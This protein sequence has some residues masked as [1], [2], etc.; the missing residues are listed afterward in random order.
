MTMRKTVACWALNVCIALPIIQGSAVSQ[1]YTPLWPPG[2]GNIVYAYCY[3]YY[4]NIVPYCWV[5]LSTSYYAGTNAH[6]HYSPSA[7]LSTVNPSS[8]VTDAS[9]NLQVVIST[10]IVGHA[11]WAACCNAYG[12]CGTYDYA[13]G[14]AGIYW[15]S[16]HG[17]WIQNGEKAIHGNSVAY[18]HWMTST[19]ALGYYY[20]TL[21]Y[22]AQHP[23]LVYSN[24][25]SLPFGGKFDLL[26]TWT[27]GEDHVS[28]DE[29]TAADTNNIPVAYRDEFRLYCKNRGAVDYREEP[30]GSLHCRW[31]Y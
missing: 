20:A 1:S 28:H 27:V 14:I 6:T 3:D 22:Q 29:G 25:M 5:S 24:D 11:E 19:A 18:N 16:D 12:N 2:S 21:D 7:P 31:S 4:G 30:N 9:G 15:V 13:V 26:G 8:G 10:T 23:G 17:I